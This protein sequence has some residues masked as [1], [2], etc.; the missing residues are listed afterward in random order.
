[1]GDISLRHQENPF[2]KIHEIKTRGKRISVGKMGVDDNVIVNNKTGEI[3][4]THVTAFKTVDSESFVKLFAENIAFTFGLSSSG[5]KSLNLVIWVLQYQGI[6]K[7]IIPIDKFALDKFVDSQS[8]D[9][10]MSIS[11]MKKGL[12]DLQKAK[13]IAKAERAGW[14]YINPHFIF[15][16]DRV[17]FT[18]CIQRRS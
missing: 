5:L 17:A 7:D 1:M 16:G 11:T 4:A 9:V 2:L 3:S 6:G 8:N 13:I 12:I 10:D 14:Y 18:T 15:N